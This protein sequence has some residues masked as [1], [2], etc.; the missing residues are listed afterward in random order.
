MDTKVTASYLTNEQVTQL[1]KQRQYAKA[2]LTR[3]IS[4]LRIYLIKN[5]ISFKSACEEAILKVNEVLD[6]NE[7]LVKGDNDQSEENIS[8]YYIYEEVIHKEYLPNIVKL[9]QEFESQQIASKNISS[10]SSVA[11][12]SDEPTDSKDEFKSVFMKFLSSTRLPNY[13]IN[14]FVPVSN[15]PEQ[16]LIFKSNFNDVLTN[17]N[18]TAEQKLTRLYTSLGD[19]PKNLIKSFL[20]DKS[21]KNLKKAVELLD[22]TFGNPVIIAER[23]IQNLLRGASIK[24]ADDINELYAEMQSA[25]IVMDSLNR[26]S[27][28]DGQNTM[29]NIVKRIKVNKIQDLWFDHV[30]NKLSE[31][32]EYPKFG[33]LLDFI[34]KQRIWANDIHY[35]LCQVS[36][37]PKTATTL[38]SSTSNHASNPKYN[39]ICLC[40]K[41]N[42]SIFKCYKFS[43]MSIDER[44]SFVYK[45]FLCLNC[46]KPNHSRRDCKFKYSCNLCNQR[47]N[48]LLHG[49][50]F[51]RVMTN[52]NN[53]SHSSNV[54]FPNQVNS[55]MQPF[56]ESGNQPESTNPSSSNEIAHNVSSETSVWFPVV[57]LDVN[58][59]KASALLDM[60][61]TGC[62]IDSNFA[63][64]LGLKPVTD[65]CNIETLSGASSCTNKYDLSFSKDENT[66]N[67]QCYGVNNIPVPCPNIDIKGFKHLRNL[68][69]EVI[70]TGS[71]DLLLGSNLG[72]ILKPLEVRYSER[73]NEP[74]AIRTA[75]G[76]YVCGTT[77]SSFSKIKNK[78]FVYVT[79]KQQ[80][81]PTLIDFKALWNVD[82]DIGQ[83]IYESA[84]DKLVV[85]LWNREIAVV[86]G[87][88]QLPIPI[89]S[90]NKCLPASKFMA[91]RRLKSLVK[92]LNKHGLYKIYNE[93]VET[94]LKEGFAEH[95][96]EKTIP[97]S[98][99]YIPHHFVPKK[100]NK[101]RIVYDCA[102]QVEGRS[103]N[104]EVLQGPDLNNTL[105]G[106]LLRFRLYPFAAMG[107]IEAMYMQVKVPPSQRDL[108]RFLWCNSDGSNIK[109]YRM[110]SHIFGG[111]WSP[112]AALF[113]LQHCATFSN[114]KRVKG[115]I[116]KSFYVDD[117]LA[118]F[119]SLQQ[120]ETVVNNVVEHL[121]G[122]GFN[123]RDIIFNVSEVD[124]QSKI[125][126]HGALGLKWH[127]SADMLSI[128]VKSEP[129]EPKLE[130]TKRSILSTVAGVFDPLGLTSPVVLKG[131]IILQE[132]VLSGVDW[133]EPLSSQ[134]VKMWSL[135][136]LDLQNL[137]KVEIPR[138]VFYCQGSSLH[139][140]VD[141]NIVSD[142][143]DL[144]VKHTAHLIAPVEDSFS[145]L[146]ER[147]SSYTKLRRI[148]GYILR[149]SKCCKKL[150]PG[151]TVEILQLAD[152]VI[153]RQA[154][155]S[156]DPTKLKSLDLILENELYRVGGRISKTYLPSKQ[157][158]VPDGAV[159]KLL[160]LQAHQLMGHMG[161]NSTLSEL[162]QRYWISRSI[163][164]SV[165]YNC[166]KC[167]ILKGT[168]STQKMSNIPEERLGYQ[169]SAFYYTGLD[170]FG[171][172]MITRKRSSC[173][174]WGLL[175]TCMTTRAIHL[176]KL[177]GLDTSSF[178]NGLERFFSRRGLPKKITCD[179][180]P[181]FKRGQK[182]LQAELH[183]LN[184]EGLTQKLANAN[185]EFSYIPPYSSHFGGVYERQIR[186]VRQVLQSM[187]FDQQFKVTDDVMNTF[188][189]QVEAIVNTRPIS[190]LH[191]R[192][193]DEP[194]LRPI[195]FLVPKCSIASLPI[196]ASTVNCYTK[197]WKRV[198]AILMA[199]TKTPQQKLILVGEYGVG[200]SSLFRR[201]AT[202][203]FTT[204]V[205]RN[206]TL[207]LDNFNKVFDIM[208]KELNLQL[209]DTGGMERVASIT[210]SYYKFAEAAILVFSYDN[211]ESFNILSQHLL[212]IV[213]HAENARIFLCGN[214]IDQGNEMYVSD[215]DIETFCE[216]CHNMISGVYKTSCKT[217]EGVQEM[218]ED[219]SRQLGISARIQDFEDVTRDSFKITAEDEVNDSCSC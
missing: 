70:R 210:S 48:T 205:D 211:P 52:G 42:H 45:H 215:N 67:I 4:S 102:A 184:S 193:N 82:Q 159:A 8:L 17:E 189:C 90:E 74:Y 155:I 140:F 197:A 160:V 91:D 199:S 110:T 119:Q 196:D 64:K 60:C 98:V 128:V 129:S 53:S 13:E 165:V 89:K 122:F 173:K 23:T 3:A 147:I 105:L 208:G 114:D 144:E 18:L 19:Y 7:S 41:G 212:D 57:Q 26:T 10:S 120:M 72:D 153:L 31:E 50:S 209:W 69:L 6:I 168:T 186:T 171:P 141:A 112:A 54:S 68:P 116:L 149:F 191:N 166:S 94:L 203:T 77:G 63:R 172:F 40:C 20:I 163:V 35:G 5:D 117:M 194:A 204:A 146:V 170:I 109:S 81:N 95:V 62:Y 49:G 101:I 207:G 219:I 76:W 113:A 177:E 96:V 65:S 156:I 200:K 78:N 29:L 71:V 106:V 214:K 103:I 150:Q 58:G 198:H 192:S 118:S 92:R 167:K 190:P 181:N 51:S 179:N 33:D 99:W 21:E 124:R 121:G 55:G 126:F 135:W 75:L 157:I 137:S 84:D 148:V 145:E 201:F 151:T 1:K 87:H 24:G 136:L 127:N 108:I 104:T 143:T 107:D 134:I 97:Q 34:G 185:I 188:F 115:I 161:V 25:K 183:K 130:I 43:Q 164:K 2:S 182:E 187:L 9:K 11:S 28:L 36:G 162:R 132:V 138:C 46:L 59:H 195:D 131:R 142:P 180:A 123:L 73:K 88:I 216:Q 15:K 152:H 37:N 22:D 176:E 38:V 100:G 80:D 12:D 93:E 218:F 14:K 111:V 178:L 16:Y 158:Y 169:Q 86:D 83:D 30:R 133:D 174:A 66:Y 61:S 202:N 217:G 139:I 85:S 47:H 125:S 32:N 56:S 79:N 39:Y 175:L 213:S 206:S 154:Q 44:C 27:E